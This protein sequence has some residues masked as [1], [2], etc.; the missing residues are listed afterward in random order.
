MEPQ[1][2]VTVTSYR[3]PPTLLKGKRSVP[4]LGITEQTSNEG[5]TLCSLPS[6]KHT[7]PG[8]K[9]NTTAPN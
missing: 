3:S 7:N 4:F 1:L 6:T 2:K 9:K 8:S 5:E